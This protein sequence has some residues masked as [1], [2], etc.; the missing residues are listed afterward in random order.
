M[1]KTIYVIAN[2]KSHPETVDEATV[3]LSQY[4]TSSLPESLSVIVCPPAVFLPAQVTPGQVV[5]GVQDVA[6]NNDTCTGEVRAAQVASIGLQY[7]IVGHSERR[8]RGETNTQVN[9]KIRQCLSAGITPIVCVGESIR[10]EV[11]HYV[12]GLTSQLDVTFTGFTRM[13]LESM[14]VAY[15]PVWAIGSG[16]T[17]ECT[18]E[19][20][21][22]T[23]ELIRAHLIH[24]TGNLPVGEI[25][26]VYGGSVSPDNARGY[27]TDGGADG[28]LI[29]RA[30]LD[31]E[32]MKSIIQSVG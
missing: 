7:A 12:A 20:C 1:K 10:D 13:D 32:K 19:E 16:A 31:I 6:E 25:K 17:R 2:W 8:A 11:G 18:V 27:V 29:G 23:I 22:E 14:I 3:L 30:S 28:L 15:E 21:R 26:V 5:L 24:M 9:Q 4:K